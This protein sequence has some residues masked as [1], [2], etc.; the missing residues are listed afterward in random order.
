MSAGLLPCARLRVFPGACGP[1]DLHAHVSP[2][3]NLAFD[4]KSK[5]DNEFVSVSLRTANAL[6]LS[7]RCAVALTDR[8]SRPK[9]TLRETL[10]DTV[11][12]CAFALGV[13]DESASSASSRHVVTRKRPPQSHC[14]L[15]VALA[16][17]VDGGAGPCP[18]PVPSSGGGG[19]P[20]RKAR[21]V[22]RLVRHGV[23]VALSR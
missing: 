8:D 3:A 11:S 5:R 13:G 17:V 2:C 19:V 4:R 9:R 10:H 15:P 1:S 20:Q 16:D 22:A 6:S 14:K 7:L 18:C 21:G 23:L 12:Q